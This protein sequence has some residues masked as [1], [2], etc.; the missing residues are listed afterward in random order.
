M[1]LP[2]SVI[3]IVV[4]LTLCWLLRPIFQPFLMSLVIHPLQLVLWAL[5]LFGGWQLIG[6][7]GPIRL[8]KTSAT[9][10]RLAGSPLSRRTTGLYS[11][12]FFLVIVG[13]FLQEEIRMSITS[14]QMSFAERSELPDVAPVRLIPKNVA[15]RYG[16]DS[17]QDPQEYLGDSQIVLMDGKLQRVFPRLPDGNILYFFNKLNGFVTV[18]VDTLERKVNIE[19]QVFAVSEGIGIFD[20][21]HFRLPLKRYFVTYSE[22]PIYLKDES[23]KWVTV[24]PYM[25][26]KGFPFTVPVWGGVMIVQPDGSMKDY[27]PQEAGELSY[28]R[29]NRIHPKE[30][31]TYYASA[32]AYRGGIINKW[33]LHKNETQVVNLQGDEEV[34]H[35]ATDEGFKQIVVAEPYGLSYGIYKIFVIDATT[36]QREVISF[37]RKSQLTGPIAA[38]DYIKKEFPTFD[39]TAFTLAE[40]RPLIV[41]EK[42]YWL[43]SIIPNDAA[44]IANTVLLDASTNTVTSIKTEA[45]L[46][47]FLAGKTISEPVSTPVTSS[48]SEALKQQIELIKRELEELKNLVK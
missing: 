28:L 23:G 30:L 20:N 6:Q 41:D 34:I 40:P 1:K 21:I 16:Q 8:V 13:L 31:A 2:G 10:Y 7:S 32:Y 44:G 19:D 14:Q 39:W 15:T 42:L 9:N 48:S 29:G 38:A 36:G 37:D 18:D 12:I 26:Y 45:E 3:G 46:Q 33:F 35:A 5:L 11:L 47:D 25:T 22:E 43:L 27:S 17:F 4:I 24:V